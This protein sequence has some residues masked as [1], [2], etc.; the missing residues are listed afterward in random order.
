MTTTTR[1]I[2]ATSTFLV[3]GA[4]EPQAV[5][6]EVQAGP[7]PRHAAPVVCPVPESLRQV[8]NLRMESLESHESIAMQVIEGDP[9]R[10]A[11][12]LERE[13]PAGVTRRYRLGPTLASNAAKPLAVCRDDGRAL[14]LEVDGRVVLRYHHAVVDPPAGI[15]PVYR[16]SGFIH[17]LLSPS[18]RAVTDDFAPDHAHQHGLFFAWVNTTFR[19][20]PVD[21]WNQKGLTGRVRHDAILGAS[22]GPVFAGLAVRLLHE[23]ITSP[24]S[25]APV[26][27]ETWSVRAYRSGKTHVVDF[28][29]RQVC[30]GR[31]PLKIN[32]Y[33]YGGLGLRGN[34]AWYDPQAGDGLPNPERSGRSDFLTS[35]GKH[36]SDGNHTRLRWVNLSGLVDGQV[37]GITILDDPENFRAPQPVRLHPNKPY[38]CF[39]PMVLGEFVIKPGP[40]YLSRYR[41]LIHDGAPD[42]G[43]IEKAWMDYAEPPRVQVASNPRER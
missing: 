25:P 17:P 4:A 32:K 22:S 18:G 36:R 26:L 21:F 29:S 27:E 42:Q 34:R 11:F 13:L 24:G 43:A 15:D 30:A 23:D 37:A 41:L 14:T 5:V 40:P 3:L 12:L 35:D 20:H 19:G 6:L 39:A 9:P 8:R 28:E 33:H 2:L 7:H 10:L 38:F 16:R 31:E 1:L